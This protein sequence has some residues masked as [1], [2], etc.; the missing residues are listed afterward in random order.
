MLRCVASDEIRD[1]LFPSGVEE[2]L[3]VFV[4]GVEKTAGTDYEV[5]SDRVRFTPPLRRR[6]GISRIGS[7][8]L[9]VGIGVY[10]K[11]DLVDLH[12]RRRG[13]IEVVRARPVDE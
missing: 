3:M 13:A 2:V 9:S 4:N 12:V 1:Y 6:E 8:L 10:P 5:L 11:G 7:I